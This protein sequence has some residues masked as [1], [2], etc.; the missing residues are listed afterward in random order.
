MAIICFK[1]VSA[2]QEQ[3]ET[4]ENQGKIEGRFESKPS[5]RQIKRVSDL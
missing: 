2:I 5:P 1:A 4:K 3:A